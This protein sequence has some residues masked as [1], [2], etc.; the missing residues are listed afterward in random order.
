M[1]C[2]LH[3]GQKV[4][5]VDDSKGNVGLAREKCVSAGAVYPVKGVVYTVREVFLSTPSNIP[6]LLL[7]E[8]HNE[9][10]SR[11]C[12]FER[13]AGFEASRFRPVATRPTSIAIFTDMLNRS[14]AKVTA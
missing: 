14:P 7:H 5:L 2:P 12:G 13:E 8:I 4:V 6:V 11:A 1:I 3:V 9:V 10:A